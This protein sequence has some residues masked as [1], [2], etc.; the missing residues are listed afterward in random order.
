M[1]SAAAA[2][3]ELVI[4]RTRGWLPGRLGPEERLGV[5]SHELSWD[6][7]R[8]A[9]STPASRRRSSLLATRGAAPPSVQGTH[10]VDH[11]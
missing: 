5:E 7:A 10:R 4:D 9:R 3:V 2:D 11:S 6:E 1:D 8:A